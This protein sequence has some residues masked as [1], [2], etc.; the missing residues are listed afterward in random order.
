LT[1][2]R[3]SIQA[4]RNDETP[5]APLLPVGGA[6][7]RTPTPLRFGAGAM[8]VLHRVSCVV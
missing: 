2:A 7:C 4:R 8:A 6:A 1:I 5:H 3:T